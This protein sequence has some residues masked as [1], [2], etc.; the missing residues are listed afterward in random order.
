MCDNSEAAGAGPPQERCAAGQEMVEAQER[1]A[2]AFQQMEFEV[3]SMGSLGA[4]LSGKLKEYKQELLASRTPSAAFRLSLLT[5]MLTT[6]LVKASLCMKRK[7]PGP[8][9]KPFLDGEQE[10][11]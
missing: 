7:D 3:K 9:P 2:Q 8:T 4:A 6:N 10:K 11:L 5:G 1:A